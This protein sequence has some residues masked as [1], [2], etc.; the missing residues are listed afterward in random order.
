[1]EAEN[2]EETLK[3]EIEEDIQDKDSDDDRFNTIDIVHH[4]IE[5]ENNIN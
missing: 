3:H 1:M 2:V 5:Y 4:K